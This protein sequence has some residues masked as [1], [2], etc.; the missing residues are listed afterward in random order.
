M[1][2]HSATEMPYFT[3]ERDRHPEFGRQALWAGR[4]AHTL[5][6][7]AGEGESAAAVNVSDVVLPLGIYPKDILPRV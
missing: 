6:G 4:P 1:R 5:L 7:R 3:N 2:R